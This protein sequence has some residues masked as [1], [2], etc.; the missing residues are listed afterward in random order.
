MIVVLLLLKK[1]FFFQTF[2]S[3]MLTS[4]TDIDR[5]VD[6][7]VYQFFIPFFCLDLGLNIDSLM[8]MAR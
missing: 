8:D 5:G 1:P 7:V 2:S 3:D 6:L 4:Q